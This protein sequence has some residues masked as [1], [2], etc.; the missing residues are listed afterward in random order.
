VYGLHDGLLR[1]LNI[2]TASPREVGDVYR[3][4]LAA[5]GLLPGGGSRS[6]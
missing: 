1:D 2:S 6:V 3:A 4:A 5:D